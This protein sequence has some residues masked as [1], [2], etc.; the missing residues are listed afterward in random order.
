MLTFLFSVLLITN[1]FAQTTLAT[2]QISPTPSE[3][4][5]EEIKKVKK[6]KKIKKLKETEKK[7]EI[8]AK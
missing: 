6:I 2:P 5:K 1:A 7:Q 4:K 8:Q 3:V